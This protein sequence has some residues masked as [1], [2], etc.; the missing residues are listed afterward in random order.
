LPREGRAGLFGLGQQRIHLGSVF[1]EVS[2]AQFARLRWS[3]GNFGVL[4]EF[5]A[6]VERKHEAA[7]EMEHHDCT[8]CVG[9]GADELGAGHARC[10]EAEA[11]AVEGERAVEIADGECDD[12]DVW[13]PCFLP[14]GRG[15]SG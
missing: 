13:F 1:D 3:H 12:V 5:A 2:D 8:S 9:F 7:S 14:V 4:G 10:V 6:R 11:V 15:W